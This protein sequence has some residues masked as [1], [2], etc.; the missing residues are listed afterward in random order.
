MSG[1]DSLHRPRHQLR[2][3][4]PG[5]GLVS[6]IGGVLGCRRWCPLPEPPILPSRTEMVLRVPCVS[7]FEPGSE[8]VLRLEPNCPKLSGVVLA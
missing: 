1:T 8:V 2:P 6:R 7:R 5:E 4:Q 3:R